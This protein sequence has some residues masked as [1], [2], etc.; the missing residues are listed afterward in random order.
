MLKKLPRFRGAIF[1]VHLTFSKNIL[2]R[3]IEKLCRQ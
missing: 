1:F 3:T 2:M